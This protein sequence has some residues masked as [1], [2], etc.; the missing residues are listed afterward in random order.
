MKK[1]ILFNI[2]SLFIAIGVLNSYDGVNMF[3]G[4][5]ESY[6]NLSMK[7]VCANATEAGIPGEYW[8]REE[9]GAKMFGPWVICA[10]HYKEHPYGSTVE[11]SLGTAIVLDTGTFANKNAEQIDIATTW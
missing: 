4:H 5:V 2:T 3:N 11:T 9:D 8:E 7:K 1:T 10:A 6:Y